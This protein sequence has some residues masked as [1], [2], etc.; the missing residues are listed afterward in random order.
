M[1]VTGFE[2]TREGAESAPFFYFFHCIIESRKYRDGVLHSPD[3][4]SRNPGQG[5]AI[6]P[7][8]S[9]ALVAPV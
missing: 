1:Q 5:F 4:A 8:M 2:V 3:G 6:H 9:A 7:F